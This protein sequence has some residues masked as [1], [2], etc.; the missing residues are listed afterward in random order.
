M[1]EDE[2]GKEYKATAFNEVVDDI[3]RGIDG[4]DVEEKLICAPVMKFT[5]TSR[6]TISSVTK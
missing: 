2:E 4:E 3:V 5:I 1:I 6:D